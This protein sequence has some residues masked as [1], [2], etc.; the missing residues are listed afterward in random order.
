MD[1]VLGTYKKGGGQA[2]N[3]KPKTPGRVSGHAGV[4]DRD[5]SL[6]DEMV[7][8]GGVVGRRMDLH[9]QGGASA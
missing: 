2:E 6:L 1:V 8:Y 4:K 7:Y 9:G 3:D 5:A